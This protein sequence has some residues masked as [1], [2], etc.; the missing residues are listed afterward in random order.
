[1]SVEPEL[2]RYVGPYGAVRSRTV[3]RPQHGVPELVLVQGFA[4]AEYL[5]PA[6]STLAGWTC[7]HLLELPGYGNDDDPA[8]GVT[9][10]LHGAAVADWLIDAAVG[11]VVLAGHSTGSQAAARAAQHAPGL[12]AG[13]V[14]ASP[15]FDPALR[16]LPR[17]LRH[18]RADRRHEEPGLMRL[19]RKERRRAGIRRL[20]R[21]VHAHL[22]DHLEE[23][24]PEL[25]M[26]VLVLRGEHDTMV[27]EE[28]A[29]GL[30]AS[31]RDGRLL[32]M[33]GAHT[34]VWN[35]P[36]AWSEPLHRFALRVSGQH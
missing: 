15:T 32:R 22:D 23:V 8:Q 14:L 12:I 27:S 19:L 30:A 34:F 29:D 36:A 6:L 20:W 28:S 7:A 13:L 24:V 18:W 33:P 31:A 9:V 25:A 1:V 11:R 16:S 10:P 26:P 2:R 5:M 21:A 3:G 17:L 4:A 35:A